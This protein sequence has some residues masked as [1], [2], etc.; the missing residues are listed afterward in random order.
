MLRETVY[1][2]FEAIVAQCT[3]LLTGQE[4][5]E[6]PEDNLHSERPGESR[7]LRID[8]YVGPSKQLRDY[9]LAPS[10]SKYT[11][12]DTIHAKPT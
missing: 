3:Y 8:S 7:T 4:L 6:I 10:A 2:A 11:D 12:L 9:K 5:S 1:S